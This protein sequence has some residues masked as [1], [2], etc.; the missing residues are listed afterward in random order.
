M[1]VNVGKVLKQKAESRK[2]GSFGKM[3]NPGDTGVCYY[4]FYKDEETG[5][6]ELL[7]AVQ[8]GYSVN[9][10]K[11]LGINTSFIPTMCEFDE[12]GNVIGAGDIAYQ[13]S[14]IAP[15]FVA[16]Q[17]ESEVASVMR[18]N[19]DESSRQML[20]KKIED[21][22]DKDSLKG[23]KPIIGSLT[24][25]ISTE[26][27]Y[28][29]MQ[30]KMPNVQE[31][32]LVAQKLSDQRIKKLMSLANDEKYTPQPIPDSDMYY[33]EVQYTWPVGEKSDAG[34]TEPAGLTAEYSIQAQHPNEYKSLLSE[35]AKLPSESETIARRNFSFTKVSEASLRQCFRSYAIMKSEYLDALDA[36]SDED[37][38]KRIEKNSGLIEEFGLLSNMQNEDLVDKINA[39]L[40][41]QHAQ[42]PVTAEPTPTAET[43]TAAPAPQMDIDQLLAADHVG[44]E[45]D[46]SMIDDGE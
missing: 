45:D 3:W 15:C 23:V 5:R 4:P 7:V 39:A 37:M 21:K 22:Y 26:C 18:K 27:V 31:A 46:L 30:N 19:V 35:I 1:R 24:F 32:R 40:E 8:R 2:S 9:D 14:R 13:F 16:G 20:L 29:P 34:K 44:S 11:E 17:K 38:I 33:L 25:Y 10:M 12:D 43:E 41:L 28:V 42:S 6:F 36:Q